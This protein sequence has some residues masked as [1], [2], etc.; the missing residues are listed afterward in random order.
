[1]VFDVFKDGSL[2]H[3]KVVG[4]A[5]N[6]AFKEAVTHA[7][8]ASNPTEPLPAG[9][10]YKKVHFTATFYYNEKLPEPVPSSAPASKTPKP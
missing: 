3:V 4:P 1:M 5:D 9:Y 7:L 10:P 6:H 8:L 2:K